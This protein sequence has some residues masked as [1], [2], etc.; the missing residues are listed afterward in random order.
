MASE[1][2]AYEYCE[3]C[4]DS[5]GRAGRDDDSLYV[6]DAGPLCL[7]C[8]T[9]YGTG[10]TKQ[11]ERDVAAIEQRI[12]DAYGLGSHDYLQGL[13][14]ALKVLRAAWKAEHGRDN[15]NIKGG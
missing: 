4:A 8:Y 6:E 5:T 1:Q 11:Y 13:S 3:L 10:C 12:I 7:G 14:D 9:A 2:E 15:S